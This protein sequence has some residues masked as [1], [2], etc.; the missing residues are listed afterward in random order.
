MPDSDDIKLILRRAALTAKVTPTER[1]LDEAVQELTKKA[2]V[3]QTDLRE[4][5]Q[6]VAGLQHIF[7]ATDIEDINNILDQ[8]RRKNK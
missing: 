4:I 7:A 6:K 2:S 1:Q 8:T 5:G 3:T